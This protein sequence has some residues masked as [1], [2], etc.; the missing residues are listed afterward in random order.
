M[1]LILGIDPGSRLTGFGIVRSLARGQCEYIASG[2]VRAGDGPFAERLALIYRSLREVIGQ[3]QPEHAAIEQVFLARNADSALKL[4]Q[5]R[6]AAIVAL[7]ESGLPVEEYT[8]TQVKQAL[9]GK[10]S[11]DKEQVRQMVMHLLK[12]TQAPQMDASDALAIAICHAHHQQSLVPHQLT[13][14]RRRSGRLRFKEMP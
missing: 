11:A 12:L 9:V 10:G 13:A 6:G 14:T 1:A 4:G 2:C 7:V 3:Y 5:A 8:A